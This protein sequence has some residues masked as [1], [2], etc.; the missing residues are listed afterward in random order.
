MISE[1]ERHGAAV[2][3]ADPSLGE[4][5]SEAIARKIMLAD[6]MVVLIAPG[7]ELRKSMQYETRIMLQNCW[8]RPAAPYCSCCSCSGC[9]TACASTPVF[10]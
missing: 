10:C 3:A 4:D 8:E 2:S 9:Y 1:L 5:W 6:L 7:D